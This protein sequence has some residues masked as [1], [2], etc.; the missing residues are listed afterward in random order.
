MKD[1]EFLLKEKLS[2]FS[3]W[4]CVSEDF[5]SQ[6]ELLNTTGEQGGEKIWQTRSKDVHLISL[7]SEKGEFRIALKSYREKRF[8]RYFM[9]PSLAA[10]EARGFAV[11]QKLG[12]PSVKV[13]AFGE[14]RSGVR[15]KSSFFITAFEEGTK[16]FYDL[17]HDPGNRSVLLE[18]LHETICRL[19]Q[20]HAYGWSH[21]GAHPRNFIWKFN[22]DGKAESIWLDLASLRKLSWYVNK[23][24]YILTDLSDLT[25]AFDLTQEELDALIGAYRRVNDIPV[26]YKRIEGNE[27]KFSKACRTGR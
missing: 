10:R 14:E 17:S 3:S 6:L 25:E 12:F 24:Q 9:R 27:R 21:G 23:W 26:E 15:L 8:F 19:A 1:I 22:A 11:V 18:L 2:F 5:V 20:L 4:Q 13:L 16:T 7:P